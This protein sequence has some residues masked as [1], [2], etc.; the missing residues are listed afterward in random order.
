M[1]ASFETLE[2]DVGGVRTVVK[3]IGRG[4]PVLYLHGAA[5]IE[6]F[7]FA[8]G[9]AD[10]FRVLCPSHPGFGFSGPAP[11]VAGMADMVLHYLNLVDILA[12]PEKPHLMG[13][14]MG[15]WMA[16]E[17]AG[18]AGERFGKVVLVA[19]AGLNDPAHP[20]AALGSI[21]PQDF[22]GYLT[23]DVSVALRYFPDGTDPAFAEAFGADRAREGETLG[24]VL[25]PF[26]MGHPNLRRFLA[27]IANP[28]LV[29]W[30]TE[31]RLL[32]ASQAPLWVEALPNARLLRVEDAGHLV[33][34]EKPDV[35]R[36]IGDFLAD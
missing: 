17:L 35:L 23:H 9:L 21:Q 26:G 29:V 3:A 13:F 4:R 32:P 2:Y 12:L 28:A 8:E 1:T 14:S 15:G 6:G 10:R 19:P 7:D 31:D 22:P 33:L 20:A 36:P 11:H 25:A 5:T 34:Q 24:R 27:R 16:S 30:G 18:L